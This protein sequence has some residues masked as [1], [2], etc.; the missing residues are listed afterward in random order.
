MD[1]LINTDGAVRTLTLNRPEAKNTLSPEMMAGL[2]AALHSADAAP[3]VRVVI[4]TNTGSTFCAGADLT[5]TRPGVAGDQ[6]EGGTSG[7]PSLGELFV[8]MQSCTK[9]VIGRIDG[10]AVGGGVG[11][12]A[13]CDLSYVRSDAKIGFTEVR[14]G[15]APAVVS[16]VCLPKLSRADAMEA[17]LTG[18]RFSPQRAA[19]MGLINGSIAPAELDEHVN[20]VVTKILRGGPN[21]VGAA[22]SLVYKVPQM[23]AEEAI[24]WTADLSQSLFA[25]E[26]AQM[27]IAA[28]RRRRPAPWDYWE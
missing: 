10:H 19:E 23:T 5:A 28:Y 15:V 16:T 27:G 21:G 20:R 24:R 13:A 22:K 11:L 14:L 9:P 25:S 12:V 26:E 2:V 18:E 3:E 4:V 6:G 7:P 17:F 1:L 8:T